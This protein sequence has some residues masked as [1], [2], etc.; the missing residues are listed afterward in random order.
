MTTTHT[1]GAAELLALI[2][3]YADARHQQGHSSYN[4]K[5]QAA[6]GAVIAALSAAQAGVP[7]DQVDLVG[8]R[9][10]G[11]HVNLGKIAMPPRMKA[12]EIARSQ[13]GGF[14]DDDGSDAELCFGALEEFIDW[15]VK[16]GWSAVP[17]PTP[18]T[19]PAQPGQEWSRDTERTAFKA[20]HQHL[21][22]DEVPD[23][24]GRPMFKHSH[25]E[26]SWLGW[27][28]R[29]ARAAPQPAT[30]DAVDAQR[31]RWLRIHAIG[32]F[33]TNNGNRPVSV[34]HLSKIPA[35]AGI[36]EETDAAID[37]ALAAQREVKP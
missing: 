21:E 36:P 29:A 37:A 23:A 20:A 10:N 26:A 24:W 32:A 1:T 18:P 12:R 33:R 28:A 9:A 14:Q 16:Q 5:T 15:R 19:A 13:F 30:A 22:L 35:I 17:Q 4:I 11:E 34:Y 3:A 6:R 31:Y 25:V 2:D 27:I 8:V 7:A